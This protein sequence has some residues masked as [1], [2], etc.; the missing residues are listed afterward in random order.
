MFVPAWPGQACSLGYQVGPLVEA[1]L[2]VALTGEQQDRLIAYYRLDP[3]TGRRLVRR[4]AIRRPKGSGKS[5]EGAYCGYA[6]LVGPVRFGG[7]SDDGQP[8]GLSHPDPWVQFAAVSEDQTDNV[9][10]W[11]FDT[12]NDRP[13]VCSERG[14]DLGRTRIYLTDRPGR[15]EPVTASAGSR[16]GQRVSYAVLDQ[17]ESWFTTN[18]G[19]R[20]ADVLRRNTAKMGGWSLELQNAPELG[21]GS[22]ADQTAKA[23]DRRSAG[24][25]FDTREPPGHERIDMTDAAQLRPALEYAYGESVAWVDVDRLIEEILDPDTD[26][27]DAKCSA[28]PRPPTPPSASTSVPSTSMSA[29]SARCAYA[30][31]IPALWPTRS[32]S[33]SPGGS[34]TSG[35]TPS[36][37]PAPKPISSSRPAA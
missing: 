23:S 33:P 20:L 25:L 3:V 12:L 19:R 36:N 34:A 24:V 14:I 35:S 9:L 16:E 31:P 30:R 2:G 6:E 26:P 32:S 22:V 18:G 17:T 7:W 37:S 13:E 8:V 27:N 5:P 28:P 29:R 1:D 15:L 11:L 21:D 10:V 4:A